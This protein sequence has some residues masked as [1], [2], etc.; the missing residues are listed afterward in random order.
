MPLENRVTPFGERIADPARGLVYGNRGCLHDEHGCILAATTASAGLLPAPVP[1]LAPPA[2]DAAGRFTELFFLDEATAFA[3][4]IAPVRSAAARTTTVCS[5]SGASSTPVSGSRRRDAQ[6]H[7]ERVAPET[8][9]Q[10]HHEAAL[11]ELPDGAFACGRAH[12]LVL[13]RELLRWTAGGYVERKRRPAR[14]QA[15]LITPPS[16]VAV[17]RSGWQPLVPLLHPS[18]TRADEPRRAGGRARAPRP[19]NPRRFWRGTCL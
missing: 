17:L 4:G 14:Q 12:L 18:V 9:T 19:P 15:R 7:A 10:L 1:R 5:R 8:R 6:L 3:A 16:L 11:D 2:V 13:G